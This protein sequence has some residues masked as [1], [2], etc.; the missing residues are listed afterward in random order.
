MS[1]ITFNG[2]TLILPSVSMG[3]V[4]QSTIDIIIA[5]LKLNRVGYLESAFVEPISGP[6]GLKHLPNK[7]CHP[8]EI[9][10]TQ[11]R[12]YTFMQQRSHTLKNSANELVDD[13]VKFIEKSGFEQ[14]I[15]LS[16]ADADYRRD[17]QIQGSPIQV[18]SCSDASAKLLA[19]KLEALNLNSKPISINQKKDNEEKANIDGFPE[20]HIH[21]AGITLPLVKRIRQTNIP[22]NIILTFSFSTGK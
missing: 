12:K 5:T 19:K 14:I 6:L 22:A 3:S 8:L 21:G 20:D 13:I 9:Y 4:P 2:S 1:E 7:R 10:Q 11:D 17:E 18:L 16:S 15:L